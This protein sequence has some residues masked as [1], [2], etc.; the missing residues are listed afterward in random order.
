[1][2]YFKYMRLLHN[3]EGDLSTPRVV[4]TAGLVFAAVVAVLTY[5]YHPVDTELA[6]WAAVN[7][8]GFDPRTR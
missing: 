3:A 6:S 8:P 7:D 1:M 4:L 5:M 2:V